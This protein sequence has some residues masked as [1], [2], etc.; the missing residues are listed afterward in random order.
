[1]LIERN[2]FVD[3]PWVLEKITNR[4]VCNS[5]DC[6]NTDLNEYFHKDALLYKQL[7]LTECYYLHIIDQ[8]DVAVALLDFCNDSINLDKYK[9]KGKI[10]VPKG[11]PQ[12]YWPAVKLTRLGV[13][14]ELQGQNIGSNILNMLKIIFI[15]ENRTGCRFLTVDSLKQSRVVHFYQT[16]GFELCPDDDR[17]DTQLLYF[18]LKRHLSVN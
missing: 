8:P 1:M 15:T 10:E 18:D 2:K 3:G 17:D 7:L 6:G 11:K 13:A 12:R 14:T 9:L 5:F 16:N 4:R